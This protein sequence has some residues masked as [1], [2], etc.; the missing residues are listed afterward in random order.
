MNK[1]ARESTQ[2]KLCVEGGRQEGGRE[3]FS[4]DSNSGEGRGGEERV[5]GRFFIGNLNRHVY[6]NLR[7]MKIGRSRCYQL[8]CYY[9]ITL[10]NFVCTALC[11]CKRLIKRTLTHLLT[12]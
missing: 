5:G 3:F 10:Y 11:V 6:S 9:L 1:H 7:V 2:T 8:C 4:G 12:Y